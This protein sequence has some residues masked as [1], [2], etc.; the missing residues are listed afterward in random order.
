M[1]KST[2]SVL[3]FSILSLI[4]SANAAYSQQTITIGTSSSYNNVVPFYGYYDYGWSAMLYNSSE[5]GSGYTINT[6][7]FD[8][9]SSSSYSFPNQKIYMAEVSDNQFSDGSYISPSSVNATLVYDGTLSYN[10]YGWKTITLQNS[11]QYSGSGNLLI[12][13]EN[14]SNY[15]VYSYP[16]FHYSY[17][18]SK[19]KYSYQNYSF[20]GSGNLSYYRP[21]IQLGVSSLS[22]NDL[23]IKEWVFPFQGA[24]TS[25]STP[26]IVKVKNNGS[27]SQSNFD[28]KY[29][30]DHGNTW[31]TETYSGTVNSGGEIT[32]SFSSLADMS[33]SGYYNMMAVV[34][35]TGD[36]LTANDTLEQN[37]LICNGGLSGTYT[38]GNSSSADFA[39]LTEALSMLKYCGVS[40]AVT[41]NM[42]SGTYN[43]KVRI[44][45]ISGT[46]ASNTITIQ[47]STS[48]ASDVILSAASSS[49]SSNYTLALDTAS[50][51]IIKNLTI[52]N[53]GAYYNTVIRL[54]NAS[55]NKVENCIL[56]TPST[57]VTSNYHSV[58]NIFNNSTT[59]GFNNHFKNNILKNGSYGFFIDGIS[60]SYRIKNLI[61]EGNTIEN[62]NNQGIYA[63]YVDSL[64][65]TKNDIHT[66]TAV[67]YGIHIKNS[68]NYLGIKQNKLNI[69]GDG[70]YLNNCN[71]SSSEPIWLN[72]NFVY[73]NNT[74]AGDPGIS[75][76]NTSFAN[77]DFNSV[78]I[79]GYNTYSSG[80]SISNG[81]YNN[82]RNNN[83]VNKAGGYSVYVNNASSILSSDYNN[84]YSNGITFAWWSSSQSSLSALKASSGKN[85]NSIT[86]LPVFY[87]NDNL[88]T[89]TSALNGAGTPI[90]GISIDIDG[91]TRNSSSPDIG[92]DE[93]S[94]YQ[95]DGG[96]T[97]FA[98]MSNPCPGAAVPVSVSL[99]NFGTTA[100][101]SANISWTLNG[102]AQTAK[103]WTGNLA[104]G[105]D[106]DIT[107]GTANL[108]AGVNYDIEAWLTSVNS[109]LDSNNF[110]DTVAISNLKTSLG[111]A[112][113]VIGSSS[114]ADYSDIDAA[115]TSLQQQGICGPTIFELESGTYNDNY[116]FPTI[117]GSSPTNTITFRSQSGSPTDVVLAYNTQ[118]SSSSAYVLSFNGSSDYFFE[119][120]TI[121]SNSSS[122]S[123]NRLVTIT[124]SEHI[125]FDNVIFNGRL[126]S[127]NSNAQMF[128]VSESSDITVKNCEFNDGYQSIL[129]NGSY[130]SDISNINIKD[131][132]FNDFY[133]TGIYL[134]YADSSE[135]SGNT[136]TDRALSYSGSQH[137]KLYNT[138][139]DIAI[140]SNHIISNSSNSSYGIYL[141]DANSSSIS[142]YNTLVANNMIYMGSSSSSYGSY[143]I[144]T[145]QSNYVDIYYNTIRLKSNYSNSAGL[146]AY[147]GTYMDVKN[148]IFH[149]EEGTPVYRYS[150][151]TSNYTS[152]Y[153]VLKGN[154][155]V[156]RNQ[157][158]YYSDLSS[159]QS[160]TGLDANSISVIPSYLSA[161]DLHVYD[162]NLNGAGT[163]VSGITT[164]IDGDTRNT[165]TPDIGA[166]EFMM[167]SRDAALV[168]ISQPNDTTGIGTRPVK[169]KIKNWGTNTLSS[170]T[171][172]WSVDGSMQTAHS[173][174]GTLANLAESNEINIGS[175]NFT[176][177]QHNIK[178]W[179]SNPNGSSDLNSSN[180]TLE[181]AVY[182]KL[183]PVIEVSP[184]PLSGTIIACN[185][186]IL[187]PLKIKNTGGASLSYQFDPIISDYDSTSTQNYSSTGAT[188]YHYFSNLD[189]NLDSL[190][191][192][193]T[194]NGDFDY[195]SE[196]VSIYFDNVLHSTFQGGSTYTNLSTTI[197][198]T[199]AVLSNYLNDKQLTVRLTNSSAVNTGYGTQ[200]HQ[201]K[202]SASGDS[203]FD[204]AGN[205]SG[206]IS[207]TDSTSVNIK[208]NGKNKPNGVYQSSLFINSNDPGNSYLEIPVTMIVNG[209][210]VIGVS[211][212]SVNFGST[213][214][215]TSA[216]DT[217]SISNTG[218]D[219]LVITNV[220]TSNSV[221]SVLSTTD[222]I[223]P[224]A[225]SEMV[226]I[227]SPTAAGSHTATATI[228]NN[229]A[230][231]NISLSGTATLPPT[232]AVSPNPVNA[233]ITNCG[234]SAIVS[235][236]LSNTGGGTLTSTIHP[237]S[238]TVHILMLTYGS[239]SGPINNLINA[240]GYDFSKYTVEQYNSSSSFSIQAKI[241]A[242]D[243]E[244][245]VIPYIGSSSSYATSISS[246][247][248]NYATNGGTVMIAGQGNYNVVQNTGLFSGSYLGYED[249][250][251]LYTAS[252]NDTILSGFPTSYYSSSDDFYYYNFTNSNLN[253]LITYNN[254]AVVA[255]R[256]IGAGEAIYVGYHYYY[257]LNT[258]YPKMIASN[259]LKKVSN[260]TASWIDYQSGT[261]NIS[262][263]NSTNK[264]ITFYSAGLTSGTH[265]SQ[266]EFITNNPTNSTVIVPCTLNVQNQIP[267]GVD[268]G[269]DTTHCGALNLD[270][271]SG[272]SS[273]LWSNNATTQVISVASSGTYSVTV[274]NGGNCVSSDT[275]QV[276]INPLPT[277]GITGV[278]SSVCEDNS[279]VSLTAYP[280]GGL[281]LGNGVSGNS[282]NPST[283]GTGTHTITYTYTN[284]YNCSNSTSTTITVHPVPTVSLS[285]LASSYCPN[286]NAVTMSGTPSGGD[287]TGT[288]VTGSTFD[289]QAAG[290]GTHQ[291]VYSYTTVY[292]CTGT[293]TAFTTIASP[294]SISISG[295]NSDY[296]EYDSPVSLTATP[297]SGTFS[298]PGINGNTFDPSVAGTGSHYIKYSVLN[299]GCL[300][301]DSVMITVHPTPVV[302]ITNLASQYCS[303]G[304]AVSISATPS[305]GSFS[306][307]G[308][309]GNT[310]DPVQAGSGSHSI[311]YS[312]TSSAGCTNTD[313]AYTN[314]VDP[315]A[316]TF[317]N[318]PNAVCYGDNP[319]S[320][321]ASPAGGTFSGTAVVAG[322]F[323]PAVAG[324]G[325]HYIVYTVTDANSCLSVDSMM[326]S[327]FAPT[328]VS[329]SGLNNTYCSNGMATTLSGSPAGGAFNGNGI[330]G[331]SFDPNTAGAG[332]HNIVYVYTNVHGCMSTD[333]QTVEVIQS[334]IA[335]AGT[336]ITISQGNSAQ[337]NGSASQG[338]G[339]YSWNW[340]PAAK[341]NNP[342][343]ANPTTTNLNNST[344]FTLQV[345]DNNT[346]C[347]DTD[348]MTVIVSGGPLS[349][350]ITASNSVICEGDSVTLQAVPS[351]GSGTYTYSWTSSPA[352]FT[353]SQANITVSPSSTTT[354]S[355]VVDDGSNNVSG[356]QQIIVYQVPTLS[357]GN[358]NNTYCSNAPVV[359]LSPSPAGGILSGNGLSG[360]SFDPSSVT[361]GI[362]QITYEYTTVNGCY[363]SITENVIVH[364]SPTAF[365]GTDTVMPCAN[366][367]LFLGQNPEPGISYLW[368]PAINLSDSSAAKPFATPNM[369]MTYTLTAI[370][371]ASGCKASDMISISISD[372]PTA[373][374]WADTTICKGDSAT[375]S[376]SGGDSYLWSNNMTDSI[377][378]V[379]PLT[380]TTYVVIASSN[381]CSDADTV[382]VN[383]NNPQPY[384]GS[385]TTICHNEMITLNPGA[386]TAYNW[387]TAETTAS[388]DVD[389]S[390]VGFG[391]KTVWVVV[392]DNIGC[393]G[394]DTIVITF[395]DCTGFEDFSESIQF[396]VYPNPTNSFITL[397]SEHIPY[398]SMNL[399]LLSSEG[400]LIETQQVQ[401]TNQRMNHSMNLSQLPKGLYLIQLYNEHF[402]KTIRIMV[403]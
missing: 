295:Y 150:Y 223:A 160:G 12:L 298:G 337:L 279:A 229:D 170:L 260:N 133:Y 70:I 332:I 177:G 56:E 27:A 22:S 209:S 228:F 154:T 40:G 388:I 189:P 290:P 321:S 183:I 106:T 402:S 96:L 21:N 299:N 11:F 341:L 218:C 24:T 127:T 188:T 13:Y 31:V 10:S 60:S 26:V 168:E 278:P 384:L 323:D 305:G 137:I 302:Q 367:G 135:I 317:N 186:S 145:D 43:G 253:S 245:V 61:L 66:T 280:A 1:K 331:N 340:S 210:P 39:S 99:K 165:S 118:S 67:T 352:G 266:L 291:I 157:S 226:F 114:S 364:E 234:D 159:W 151:Y 73:I 306:G 50:H 230:N 277:V 385:D 237:P 249:Y 3:L 76:Y 195:S 81:A 289:P 309:N 371:T 403:Q 358:L 400:K 212:S 101:T 244:L 95:T 54:Q 220:T 386:F 307:T 399:A 287:Y 235:L 293:D 319:V 2:L 297:A 378:N 401:I 41:I 47:S 303:N 161:N 23:T 105:V 108:Q 68:E 316:I 339:S 92:A 42:E 86:T 192:T 187:V 391:A 240:F 109:S 393:Q 116:T 324:T 49:S 387:S 327:V 110:N 382:T 166:D 53:T 374:A 185:D 71:G 48:T 126:N 247:L 197:T 16:R 19:A 201:V 37:L 194:I 72:N 103:S 308:I 310:F 175:Y 315:A 28:L 79:T 330:A 272:Y 152:D 318:I 207:P 46:S 390:G 74:S 84:L 292:G 366:N 336:D 217:V 356:S 204:I 203:W 270:A 379:S 213:F 30:I 17:N 55:S 224:D 357:I 205:S 111:N 346:G 144:Y 34:R 286:D 242:M 107:I 172:N 104:S 115:L 64:N 372:G 256:P 233:T 85:Q 254:Y 171:L 184:N 333:T 283:A 264:N 360:N 395:D 9:Y 392:E 236:N 255:N 257:G 397:E 354:Y 353:S 273:Y 62:F 232:L 125:T 83:I 139:S 334:A 149:V 78:H 120:L 263:G 102:T 44:P 142:T 365:A 231:T 377:I 147:Y 148:N 182:A 8:V 52:K 238:D 373:Y 326:I 344:N 311:I 320:L 123:Y 199:G 90:T 322:S 261:D 100:I 362:S 36:T 252:I 122:S 348:D 276:T 329:F 6:L 94:I 258:N 359:T 227:Y 350:G 88:H 368:T 4:L 215:N 328:P 89:N 300:N 58:V 65:I 130:S 190:V 51:I 134:S 45:N 369:S 32:Y 35:N 282:F 275:I 169:V 214:T 221:F 380:T 347:V 225:T 112:T 155:Y 294:V 325:T 304:N 18:S 57:T 25:S 198:L 80:I 162:A 335:N 156:G 191:V 196:Y 219:T 248:Q 200:L 113:Y 163:P 381:G 181:K 383:V 167:L 296:C 259:I 396:K 174:T 313:T 394:S 121:E 342:S 117:A 376:V 267:N 178:V 285:G 239:S 128:I 314:V 138:E 132:T 370:D 345:T 312:Y 193:I 251:T 363:T 349:M 241:N 262:A 69:E 119:D 7:A 131:N 15:S 389:S 211:S 136:L 343:V 5:V 375:L 20:P 59:D 164:D 216:Y 271:G 265:Y 87:S 269:K 97:E 351:G 222:T 141:E 158:S 82:L 143:G 38:V 153:N 180:D 14:R 129:A 208:L 361:S 98:N 281:Y 398:Q 202:L 75:T 179:V 250:R 33:A 268:L 243:P 246:V 288:G 63:E 91:E 146:Y 338:S 284:A 173:W 140:T 206:T 176:S 355:C 93:F 124:N 77:I 29:S 301:I 274:S